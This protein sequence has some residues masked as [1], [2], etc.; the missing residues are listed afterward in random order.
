MVHD[1]AL[2]QRNKLHLKN[3]NKEKKLFKNYI[4][5]SPSIAVLLYFCS[6]KFR[7]SKHKRLFKNIKNY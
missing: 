7:I 3:M 1:S 2:H 6:N 5:I 4:N